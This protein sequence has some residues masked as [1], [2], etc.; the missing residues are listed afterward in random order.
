MCSKQLC[1][2]NGW[3]IAFFQ[4]KEKWEIVKKFIEHQGMITY[5]P[6]Y[7]KLG[8]ETKSNCVVMDVMKAVY[9]QI[10]NT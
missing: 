1:T 6:H 10:T 2:T 8:K 9:A 4:C 3:Q 7:A 5:M